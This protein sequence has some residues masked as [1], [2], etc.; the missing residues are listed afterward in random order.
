MGRRRPSHATRSRGRATAS[1]ARPR[2]GYHFGIALA[3]DRRPRTGTEPDLLVGA[4]FFAG[5]V[6]R[7][8][9]DGSVWQPAGR[10]AAQPADGIVGSFGVLVAL[11]AGRALVG[12]YRA[13][14]QADPN[15]ADDTGAA[16]VF[17]PAA[18]AAEA[19][20]VAT[21]DVLPAP[22]PNPAS[23]HTAFM[24]RAAGPVR[25]TLTDALGRTVQTLFDGIATDETA[26]AA[27]VSGLPAGVYGV[28][29]V[30]PSVSEGRRL[31]VVR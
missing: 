29:V 27:D 20:P 22:R 21:G 3:L 15:P 2:P 28:R 16:Y 17:E 18:V 6:Y 13:D 5:A 12:A 31:T 23:G 7:Y 30:G 10:I 24:L 14:S 25:V 4:S 8:V 11:D 19:S 26:L 9:R 1:C